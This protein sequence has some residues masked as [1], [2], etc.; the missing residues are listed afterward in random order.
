MKRNNLN[1]NRVKGL[2]QTKLIALFI[3]AVLLFSACE[4]SEWLAD[5]DYFF[6][7]HKG[8]VMP[9]WVNGNIASGT[10]IITNHGGPMRNS[11]HDFHLSKAFKQLEEDYAVIYWDQRMSGLAQGDPKIEDL[12]V[13]QHIED[14]EQLT[15]L[16]IQLYKPASMF[17]LGHSWGGALT[18]GYLGSKNHQDLFKGWIDMDGSIQDEFE[19]QAKKDWI[20]ARIDTTIANSDNPEFWQF[21]VDWYEENPHPEETNIEPYDYIALLGGAVYDY[22]KFLEEAP[23]PYKELVTSS[24]FTFAFYWAQHYSRDVLD[25]IN[26]F[27]A[28]PQVRNIHIPSLLIWGKEDGIVPPSVGEFVYDLLATDPAD[29]SLVLIEECCHSPF[30]EQPE[31]FYFHVNTFIEKYK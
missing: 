13:E 8:A 11:G 31:E 7:E 17:L 25:W 14:L 24:P 12:S 21:I 20:F 18:A 15:E 6:L 23:V 5:G 19:I 2:I 16:I 4:K 29:K 27:D 28:T 26:D 3:L 30:N 9:V 1:I 10:F 22:E